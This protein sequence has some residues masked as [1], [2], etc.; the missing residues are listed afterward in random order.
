MTTCYK[1]EKCG[2]VF[3]EYEKA[4]DHESCHFIPKA[5]YSEEDTK[6]INANTEWIPELYAP[7]AVVVPMERTV[8]VDGEWKNEVAYVKYYYSTK[9]SAEQVFPVDESL[10]K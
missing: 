4:Y 7:S 8:F 10:M 3:E 2:K 5:W 9:H 6:V 1:C